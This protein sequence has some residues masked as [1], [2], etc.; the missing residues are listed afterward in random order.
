MQRVRQKLNS[1]SG[2]TALFAIVIFAVAA[3]VCVTIVTVALNNQSRVRGQQAQQREML[4]TDSAAALLR[5]TF[6]NMTVTVTR[7]EPVSGEPTTT[8]AV[9][10]G[11]AS[12]ESLGKS[13]AE[14][15]LAGSFTGRKLTLSVTGREELSRE[16]S[17]SYDGSR[18]SMS[19]A[20]SA[21]A[22]GAKA[23]PVTV[24]FD[25]ADVQELSRIPTYDYQYDAEGNLVSVTIISWTVTYQISLSADRIHAEEL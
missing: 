6:G 18:L 3:F 22:D 13:L 15:M 4:A 7:V 24:V 10:V 14:H 25:G 11:H 20:P 17:M 21:A 19:F 9:D 5:E 8:Y 16:A 12:I 1:R 23:P 2:I